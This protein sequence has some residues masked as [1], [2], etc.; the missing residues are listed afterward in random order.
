MKEWEKIFCENDEI[1]IYGAANTAKK[2]LKLARD[3]D[4]TDKI[5]G[6]VVTDSTKNPKKIDGFEVKDIYLL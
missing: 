5:G 3:T 1:Y 6:L 4:V 2:F